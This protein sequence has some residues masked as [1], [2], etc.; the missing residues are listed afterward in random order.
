MKEVHGQNIHLRVRF[1]P[2]FKRAHVGFLENT[3]IGRAQVFSVHNVTY[4][5]NDVSM[6]LNV[7]HW[8][9]IIYVD[10]G[11]VYSGTGVESWDPSVRGNNNNTIE[12]LVLS[13]QSL[14][15]R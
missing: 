8:S 14:C 10:N 15:L 13:V 7:K 11:D 4:L 12:I 6:F 5:R 2:V 3:C 1:G 9:V